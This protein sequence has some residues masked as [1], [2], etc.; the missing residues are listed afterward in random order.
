MSRW[1]DF[2]AGSEQ[3]FVQAGLEQLGAQPGED[4]LEV[5]YGT[6]AALVALAQA[7]Q[8][9]GRVHGIDLS[10]GMS[11]MAREKLRRA[12]L[13]SRVDLTCGDG[14]RLPYPADC[15]DALFMS[16]TLELFDTPEIPRVLAEC[17]R[18]L[19]AQGRLGVVSLAKDRDPSLMV[20]LYEWFHRQFPA[21]IDC[22]PIPVQALLKRNRF[23]VRKQQRATMWGLPVEIVVAYPTASEGDDFE[24]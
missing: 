18:V 15:F 4:V 19:K 21:Y 12:E 6:G 10:M 16:F 2:L 17:R 23:Q 1:Y 8:P 24:L 20:R 14:A 13:A 22:R 11:R 7:V 5:G 9:E 3:K